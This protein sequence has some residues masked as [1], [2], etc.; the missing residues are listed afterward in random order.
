MLNTS[1]GS[2]VISRVER[3]R[4]RSRNQQSKGGSRRVLSSQSR[5]VTG[6]QNKSSENLLREFQMNEYQCFI[7]RGF[8]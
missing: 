2:G 7:G 1:I 8:L 3:S 6:S 4:E 5:A